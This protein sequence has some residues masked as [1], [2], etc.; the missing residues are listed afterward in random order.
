MKR[1]KTNKCQLCTRSTAG[2]SPH[3]SR[4]TREHLTPVTELGQEAVDEAFESSATLKS[5]ILL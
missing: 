2:R 1:T 3:W 5:L 4:S